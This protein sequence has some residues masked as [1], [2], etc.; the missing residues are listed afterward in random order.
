MS[1]FLHSKFVCCSIFSPFIWIILFYFCLITFSLHVLLFFS[2]C[3]RVSFYFVRFLTFCLSS[4]LSFFAY[5]FFSLFSRFIT[6]T[7]ACCSF[8]PNENH[9]LLHIFSSPTSFLFLHPL[10][11]FLLALSLPPRPKTSRRQLSLRVI[12]SHFLFLWNDWL[13]FPCRFLLLKIN[14]PSVS[15]SA[16]PAFYNYLSG[17]A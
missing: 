10:L 7:F 14:Y 8:R 12:L 9:D 2:V 17:P 5:S 4:V 1:L 6:P 3:F 11:P 15:L 16:L 13:I